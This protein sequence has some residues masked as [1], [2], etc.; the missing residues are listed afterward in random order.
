LNKLGEELNNK[1]TKCPN[2]GVEDVDVNHCLRH[3]NVSIVRALDADNREL[4]HPFSIKRHI[5]LNDSWYA[6][7]FAKNVGFE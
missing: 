1:K 4:F 5:V 2:T 7:D 6:N 3:L